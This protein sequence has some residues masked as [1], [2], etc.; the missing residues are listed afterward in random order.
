MKLVERT[1][2]TQLKKLATQ[3][4]VVTLTGPR[5]SG[6]TTLCRMAFPQMAYANLE[7]PDQREFAADASKCFF[8]ETAMGMKSMR[9]YRGHNIMFRWKLNRRQRFPRLC[10]QV[11][12][13]SVKQLKIQSTRC[14]FT[15][16]LKSVCRTMYRC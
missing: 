11:Y 6:K 10:S 1:A 14:W 12:T 16:A 3:Y 15:A 9:C 5:Q 4:P 13:V 2:E 7:R 8:I